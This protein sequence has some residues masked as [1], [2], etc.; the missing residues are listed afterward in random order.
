MLSRRIST[1]CLYKYLQPKWADAMIRTGSIRV[2]T[3]SEY[4]ELEAK[5]AER[6]DLGE[7]TRVLHSDDRPRVYNST[8]EL[9]SI[10]R[11]VSCGPR[12]MATNGPS[13]IVIEQRGPDAHLYCLTEYFD[14]SVMQQFGGASVRIERP[15][16]FFAAV[17]QQFRLE[18]QKLDVSVCERVLDRC[19]YVSRRQN[20]HPPSPVHECFLKPPSYE[21]Q[22]EVRAVWRPAQLPIAP[23]E[24]DCPQAVEYCKFHASR[25]R[26]H[27]QLS[28]TDRTMLGAG[29][30]NCS[31]YSISGRPGTRGA[32]AATRSTA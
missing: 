8:T 5:D 6:G 7:G 22:R 4:R 32:C 12:G 28:A 2:G 1:P 16:E 31:C 26:S 13:A 15:D 24:F 11:G 29:A 30:E 27:E 14:P 21:H 17:D 20:Y 25:A 9:P 3:L 18:L 10:L 23:I 19:V